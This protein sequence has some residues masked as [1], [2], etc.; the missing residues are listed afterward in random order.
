MRRRTALGLIVASGLAHLGCGGSLGSPPPPAPDQPTQP[1][2]DI[3]GNWVGTLESSNLP[4]RTIALTV[5]QADYC[6]DGAWSSTPS[7]WTGAI[8][9]VAGTEIYAGQISIEINGAGSQRCSGVAT[10]SSPIGGA[11]F[12]WVSSGF[13]A[14]GTCNTDLPRDVIL[15]MR[16]AD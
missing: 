15:R 4:T 10:T 6:V 14:V 9:G 1:A 12:V 7:G 5:V 8:S 13:S 2:V 11:T 3:A 16:R